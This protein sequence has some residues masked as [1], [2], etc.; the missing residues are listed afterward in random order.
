[1][2][3][4]LFKSFDKALC[5]P[6][7]TVIWHTYECSQG[8]VGE[9][10]EEA[11]ACREGEGKNGAREG[12]AHGEAAADRRADHEGSERYP[13][14]SVWVQNIHHVCCDCTIGLN[15]IK[16][17]SV[18]SARAWRTDSPGH[19]VGAGKTESTRG[20][21]EAGEGET[22]SWRGQGRAGQAGSRPAEDPRATGV[23]LAFGAFQTLLRLHSVSVTRPCFW[24]P[25][26]RSWPS[27]QQRLLSWR[28]PRGRRRM[29]PPSG[30][31]RY[32]SCHYL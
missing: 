17:V 26:P 6:T 29:R 7:E 19:G 8:P 24:C 11:R 21:R 27:S 20:G 25:R 5:L 16:P 32:C 3:L 15:Q 9:W 14:S 13:Y 2:I 31:T 30:S 1:M 28:R 10:K 12:R 22:S 23:F 18:P 4:Y